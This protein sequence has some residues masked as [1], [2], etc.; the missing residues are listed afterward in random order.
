MASTGQLGRTH[1]LN[2]GRALLRRNIATCRLGWSLGHDVPPGGGGHDTV[3]RSRDHVD[4]CRAG[5]QT[6]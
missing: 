3:Q 5:W 4:Y 2:H 6:S 1:A